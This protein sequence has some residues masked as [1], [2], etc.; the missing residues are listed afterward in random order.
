M[1]SLP[2]FPSQAEYLPI[3]VLLRIHFQSITNLVPSNN[4][5]LKSRCEHVCTSSDSRENV[6]HVLLV[7]PASRVVRGPLHSFPPFAFVSIVSSS[8]CAM[9]SVWS[10][11]LI[12]RTLYRGLILTE[13][14]S[15][16]SLYF[17]IKST[18]HC[19]K[20]KSPV[21]GMFLRRKFS[22]MFKS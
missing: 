9:T 16:Q 8:L 12:G 7:P 6:F 17:Q 20:G 22:Q 15:L 1:S 21:Q 18:S 2:R 19:R 5:M 4:T 3:P 11:V 10:P 13:W 14:S